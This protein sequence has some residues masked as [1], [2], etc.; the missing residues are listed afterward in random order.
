M[1]Q[2]TI[3]GGLGFLGSH[4]ASRFL[5]EGYGVTIIDPVDSN[6]EE[7]QLNIEMSMGRHA[8]YSFIRENVRDVSV[9]KSCSTF[10]YVADNKNQEDLQS[11]FS[12]LKKDDFLVFISTTDVYTDPN[13]EYGIQ[14]IKVEKLVH[15]KATDV[16]CTLVMMRLPT[17]YGL[18][19]RLDLVIDDET[20]EYLQTKARYESMLDLI[21]I[22]DVTK[23]VV[24][25]C[26]LKQGIY[27]F[28]L[29]SGTKHPWGERSSSAQDQGLFNEKAMELIDFSPSISL[30]EG[31]ADYNEQRKKWIRQNHL[32]SF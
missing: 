4:I 32:K 10:I 13:T 1:E 24:K 22:S 3:I 6:Y 19:H 21:Y 23:A 30:K 15:E 29:G 27:E 12:Q 14:M 7:E 31:I 2:V 28:H 8:H 25:S 17:V 26:T 20:I 9:T 11:F 18:H 16:E 5:H